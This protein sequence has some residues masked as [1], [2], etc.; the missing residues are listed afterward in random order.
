MVRAL[1]DG[2]FKLSDFAGEASQEGWIFERF[3]ASSSLVCLVGLWERIKELNGGKW[4]RLLN[5]AESLM[6]VD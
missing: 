4:G 1:E 3:Y 2:L 6:N 5:A